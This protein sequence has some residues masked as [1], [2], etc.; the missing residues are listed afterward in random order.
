MAVGRTLFYVWKAAVE[1]NRNAN[2]AQ[3]IFEDLRRQILGGELS[4]GER[5]LGERELATRYGTNRNTLREAVRKLEQTRL[6]SVRHGRGVSVT[7]FR[8]AGTLELLSPYLQSGPDIAE[9][10]DIIEDVLEPRI[11]LL[12]Y[13]SRVAVRRAEPADIDRLRDIGDLLIAAFEAGDAAV[14]ARGFQRWL[15]AL[16]EAGHSV[17]VRWIANSL[18]DALRDTLER[19]PN[20]W[21]LEPTFPSYLREFVAALRDGDEEAAVATTRAYYERVDRQLM[22]LLRAGLPPRQE[23]RRA[24]PEPEPEPEETPATT[25]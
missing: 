13:A 6:V 15:D 8:R 3:H 9:V 22:Q 5:L 12:E 11:L 21:I 23:R 25:H 24:S 19:F 14:V 18:F 7:D 16:V 4:P 1:S 2:I 10:A 20:L 17:A